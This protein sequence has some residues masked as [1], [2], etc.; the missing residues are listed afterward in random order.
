MARRVIY[1]FDEINS[2]ASQ[3]KTRKEFCKKKRHIYDYAKEKGWLDQVSPLTDI[4]K[5]QKPQGY[6][7]YET[8]A[9]DALK[10]KDKKT[11]MKKYAQAYKVSLKN[12]WIHDIC[13]HMECEGRKDLRYIYVFEFNDKRVYV[14]LTC[15][16]NRRECEHIGKSKNSSVKE[17]IQKTN[18]PFVFKV[19]T[20]KPLNLIDAGK[21]EDQLM[22]T[23]KQNGWTLLN[24]I[25]GGGIGGYITKWTYT[26]C[27]NKS[28]TCKT[29]TEFMRKYPGAYNSAAKNGW[30]DYDRAVFEMLLSIKRAGAD[31]IL[32][33]FAK[34]FAK[35]VKK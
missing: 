15:D 8:C 3:F 14:G 5:K 16:L 35:M 20:D 26:A 25:K 2:V 11:F 33:Y 21:L 6:Y 23:Y 30:L 7:N 9:K 13:K 31:G 32:T 22:D 10:C 17:H 28:F 12:G 24:K 29:R 4:F 1:T 27:K 34:D 19:I 18:N